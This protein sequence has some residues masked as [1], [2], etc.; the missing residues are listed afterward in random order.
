MHHH[1]LLILLLYGNGVIS[2]S[3][4]DTVAG[5]PVNYDESRVPYYVLPDALLTESGRPV[6]S[7]ADWYEQRRPEILQLFETEQFGKAPERPP[8]NFD[9]YESGT[10]AFENRAIRRQVTVYLT[11]DTTHHQADLLIYTPADATGPV[12]V[13][14]TVGFSA[15]SLSFDDP[16]IREGTV[17]N[18]EGKRVPAAEGRSFGTLDIAPFLEAGIGVA[19]IYYG[20]IE[21]DFQDGIS[22]GVRGHHLADGQDYPDAGQ[23]GTIAAWA[24][25]LSTIMDY[26]ET[27]VRVDAER[28]AVFGA[29]RL[30]KTALWTGARD[31]RFGMVIAC[32]SG[33]GGAALSRREYGET[34]AHMIDS[35]RYDYQFAGNRA[36][37]GADPKTSPVDGHLLLSLIAP[38]PLL[39]Q[40]GT[41]DYWSDPKGEFEAAVA[42]EPVYQLL[43]KRGLETS[44]WPGPGEPILHDLGYYMHDGGHGPAPEDYAVFVTFMQQHF[45]N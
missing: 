42:A 39:L 24:W 9:V 13:F 44:R 17:W 45:L 15:N 20:D 35:N 1:L 12:P 37:Y 10:P 4:T 43:G 22:Y 36:K 31:S 23:W 29:S 34:T 41:T 25:G 38:R 14:L 19:A 26:L 3:T 8:L 18:R 16:A 2:Q 5:I 30:G 21:P 40:T 28:V 27:D 6:A 11:D 7:A 33:E 32:C